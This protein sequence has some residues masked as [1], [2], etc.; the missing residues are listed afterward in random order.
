M[1]D[2][3]DKVVTVES[4]AA[5]HTHGKNTYMTLNN[6]SGN[7]V[8]SMDGDGVFSGN[9]NISSLTIGDT[10]LNYDVAEGALKISFVSK[11]D[12]EDESTDE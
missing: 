2:L 7:G 4:L 9:I 10:I 1:A 11:N 5:V 8:L 6:P 12:I 3:K